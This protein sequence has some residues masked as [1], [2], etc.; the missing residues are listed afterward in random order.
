MD[1]CFEDIEVKTPGG[2]ARLQRTATVSCDNAFLEDRVGE[3][4]QFDA[5]QFERLYLIGKGDVG[6]VYLCRTKIGG[7]LC[8][9]KVLDQVPSPRCVGGEAAAAA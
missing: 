7:K 1:A 9:V 8:A 5:S 6:R 3:G 4:H 2:S